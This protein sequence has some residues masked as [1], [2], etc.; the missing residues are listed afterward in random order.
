MP[1]PQDWR[2]PHRL[3]RL[4][5]QLGARAPGGVSQGAWFARASDGTPVVLKWSPDK[6]MADRYAELLLGLDELRARG[7]P[8]PEYLN[9]IP[10]DGGTLSAQQVLPGR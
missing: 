1:I 10:F 8:V 6:T 2:D 4:G 3:H 9:V 5:F 7:V